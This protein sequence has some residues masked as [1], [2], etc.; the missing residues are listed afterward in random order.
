MLSRASRQGVERDKTSMPGHEFFLLSGDGHWDEGWGYKDFQTRVWVR[1][2]REEAVNLPMDFYRYVADTLEWIP[3]INPASPRSWPGHGLNEFGPT[4]INRDGA[5]VFR[6]VF[7]SWAALLA[8]GP[9]RIQLTGGAT[10]TREGG[11]LRSTGHFAK[12]EFD[13]DTLVTA[14]R[15]LASYGMEVSTGESFIVHLGI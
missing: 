3:S 4:L 13:R 8:G 15:T 6:H 1:L 14:L 10:Y 2:R 5:D 9:E 11:V 12:Y 7:S